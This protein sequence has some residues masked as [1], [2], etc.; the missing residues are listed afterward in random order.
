MR[1]EL[2]NMVFSRILCICKAYVDK[3]CAT[4]GP[5]KKGLGPENEHMINLYVRITVIVTVSS[6]ALKM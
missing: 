2:T 3:D 1:G 5:E 4:V 6:L